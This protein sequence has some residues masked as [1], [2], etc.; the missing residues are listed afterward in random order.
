[1]KLGYLTKLMV[2][3]NEPFL[4]YLAMKENIFSP[5]VGL[6]PQL[7]DLRANHSTGRAT[8]IDTASYM[9]FETKVQSSE[10]GRE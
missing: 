9:Q 2:F 4:S 6:E 8:T 3:L 7:S 1:M 5:V 10:S